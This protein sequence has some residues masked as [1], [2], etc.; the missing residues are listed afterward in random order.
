MFQLSSA[1]EA[2]AGKKEKGL[3][4]RDIDAFWLQRKLSKYYDD[5]MEAQKKA[6][7]V[8][9]VLKVRFTGS[10]IFATEWKKWKDYPK[11]N[12]LV[13]TNFILSQASADDREAENRLVILLGFAQF[14]FIKTIRQY[15]QMSESS[16]TLIFDRKTGTTPVEGLTSVFVCA[17]MLSV[18]WC[19]LRMQAQSES[20]KE[21]IEEKMKADGQLSRYLQALQ[22]TDKEDIVQEERERREASRRSLRHES[23]C[24]V[25]RC[26]ANCIAQPL[27]LCA[28]L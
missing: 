14:D 20:E 24:V 2:I 3:H 22:E 21:K 18:L 13:K 26:L 17:C 4:P 9:D 12:I 23:K 10:K 1:E 16:C 19:T 15:R 8:L 27:H 25:F 28:C 6:T 7:E 5:P 11:S